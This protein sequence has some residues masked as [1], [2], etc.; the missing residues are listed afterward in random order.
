M[1]YNIFVVKQETAGF[2][3]CLLALKNAKMLVGY[4]VIQNI[5]FPFV[6][7]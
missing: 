2:P 1:F 7:S 5:N 3:L 6:Y 4:L